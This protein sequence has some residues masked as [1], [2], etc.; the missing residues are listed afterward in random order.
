MG[1]LSAREKRE[2]TLIGRLKAWSHG[3][4]QAFVIKPY[5]CHACQLCIAACPEKALH[6]APIAT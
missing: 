1:T 4:K 6:L 3:G 2:L 5:D